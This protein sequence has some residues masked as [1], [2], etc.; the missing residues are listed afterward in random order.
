LYLG[1]V[2]FYDPTLLILGTQDSFLWLS[3][4]ISARRAFTLEG[5]PGKSY[6]SLRYV[7][8]AG[9]GRMTRQGSAFEWRFSV[10][11][12]DQVAGQLESLAAT[13]QPRH[14]YLDPAVNE[15]E[16]QIA[17]VFLRNFCIL[18]SIPNP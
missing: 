11:E 8:A 10:I 2:D 17:T 6:V 12:S 9:G 13:D 15:T 3:E 5:M 7:T 1:L 4:Q 14:A 16:V 18:L